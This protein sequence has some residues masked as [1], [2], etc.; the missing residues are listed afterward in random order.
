MT[1]DECAKRLEVPEEELSRIAAEVNAVRPAALA[2]YAGVPALPLSGDARA[3]EAWAA[4]P[5]TP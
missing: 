1:L 3:P 4:S 5:S 2:G